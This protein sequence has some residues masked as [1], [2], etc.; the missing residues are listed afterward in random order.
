MLKKHIGIHP[1]PAS[2]KKK[3]S[4][5]SE[6]QKMF[7]DRFTLIELLVVIAIIAI[8]A[9]MLLP[10]LNGAK[11]RSK[12]IACANKEKQLGLAL[13]MYADSF[14]SF[15]I[16]LNQEGPGVSTAWPVVLSKTG[17]VRPGL[18]AE[19]DEDVKN[20]WNCP[21]DID[22]GNHRGWAFDEPKAPEFR[23]SYGPN[24]AGTTYLGNYSGHTHSD[25]CKGLYRAAWGHE[26]GKV[27]SIRYPSKFIAVIEFPNNRPATWDTSHGSIYGQLQYYE[28]GD[29]LHRNLRHNYI[30]LD[31]HLETMN[32]FETVQPDDPNDISWATYLNRW[33]GYG[34]WISCP[35]NG[36]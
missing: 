13:A 3:L 8:L 12:S 5:I 21:G 11:E 22:M 26:T 27:E 17:F 16:P 31:L 23:R 29:V 34:R 25:N 20:L 9:A 30:M 6:V 24:T 2:S 33:G 4:Q 7:R 14:N 35:A 36:F 10:A 19:R 28:Q 15:W 1:F 32:P 18:E